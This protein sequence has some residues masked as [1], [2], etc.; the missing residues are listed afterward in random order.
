MGFHM[1]GWWL[2]VVIG[3]VAAIVLVFRT[4]AN[5]RNS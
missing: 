1:L 3:L 4:L 2:I 5:R